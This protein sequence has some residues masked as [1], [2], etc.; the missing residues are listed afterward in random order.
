MNGEQVKR[1]AKALRIL[2]G[3]LCIGLV[4]V[5]AIKVHQ[6]RTGIPGEDL[7][8]QPVWMGIILMTAGSF[9]LGLLVV[10]PVFIFLKTHDV[11]TTEGIPMPWWAPVAI[12][13]G[14]GK[15]N[16]LVPR[17]LGTLLVV[18]MSILGGF[19]AYTLVMALVFG[20][21]LR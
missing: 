13:L 5:V 3:L 9:F 18:I 10:F 4:G 14:F 7:F 11:E 1:S 8:Y 12:V 20:W 15:A 21:F 17:S 19:V 2:R 6:V 16:W